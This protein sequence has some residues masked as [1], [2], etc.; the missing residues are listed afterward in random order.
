MKFRFEFPIK[1][2]PH[3]ITHKQKLMLMGSCFTENIGEKLDRFKFTTLQ[4]P[5]G[6]L[7][8]PV[9]VAEA[10]TDYIENRVFHQ[11]DLFH[12]NEGWHSWKHHSRFS[13]IK[14]EE[15]L[16]KINTST[17]TAHQFLQE[18]DYL[19]IT[20]GSSWVYT[21][22]EKATNAIVSSVAANNHKAPADWFSRKLLQ[23]EDVLRVLDNIIHRLFH[24]NARLKII[25]TISPVRH[26]REGVVE[27]NRS[28]AGL[29][30]AVHHLVD[31]FERLFYFPAYELVIDDLR[32]YRFYAEDLVHPNY[33]ATQYVWE[34]LV[35]ACM[36]EKTKS[37]MEEIHTINLAFQHRAFN[38]SSSQ[39]KQ[40]LK[41]SYEKTFALQQQ[42]PFLDLQ[43]EISFFQNGI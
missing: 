30:Q 36:D 12:Y 21:L 9:S 3:P 27:N 38:P 37:L 11:E 25:F 6:I 5:N 15:A 17:S 42:A 28:K 34:K 2:L 18:S 29:I 26:L 1:K 43:R 31:K 13:G 23:P 41:K 33:F 40:F 4:N 7:F 35:D 16:D 39:H 8:N 20:L 19:I 10:L 24:F 14:A 32:D 22:T